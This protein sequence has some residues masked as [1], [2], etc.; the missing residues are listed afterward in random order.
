MSPTGL[1]SLNAIVAAVAV[2][3]AVA[4]IAN[5]RDFRPIEP[6]IRLVLHL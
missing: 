1:R 4:V 3:V 5:A 6:K 2:A